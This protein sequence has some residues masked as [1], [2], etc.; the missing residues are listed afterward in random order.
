MPYGR[1]QVSARQIIVDILQ[2]NGVEPIIPEEF[3]AGA[4]WADEMLESLRLSDFIIADLSE[5]NPN[6]IFELGVAHGLRKP[7]IILISSE[8]EGQIP[9]D[10]SGYQYLTYNPHDSYEL[11]ERLTRFVLSMQKRLTAGS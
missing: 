5:F 10:L 3:V 6:V 7:F 1:S 9:S 2:R 11:H 4:R 8:S